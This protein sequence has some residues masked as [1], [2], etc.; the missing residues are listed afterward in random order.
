[1]QRP[2]LQDAVR[3]STYV[4]TAWS[5]DTL[6][7]L[8]RCL[9]DDVSICYLQDILIRPEYQRLGVG[10]RL[11]ADCLERF[12]HVRMQVLMTDDEERQKRFYESMGYR[13]TRDLKSITL[14]AFVRMPGRDLE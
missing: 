6:V 3:N 10:R 5:G 13:N 8:A 14:N 12:A 2:K 4:V 9:S 11:L 1:M 7:G